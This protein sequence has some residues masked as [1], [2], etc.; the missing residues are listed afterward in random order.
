[1]PSK[2]TVLTRYLGFSIILFL[3]LTI[4]GLAVAPSYADN[5]ATPVAAPSQD[6]GQQPGNVFADVPTTYWAYDFINKLY[7]LGI[8][9]GYPDKTIK[10]EERITRAEFVSILVKALGM[11]EIISGPPVFD[12]VPRSAGYYG[13]VQSAAKAGLVAGGEGN[14]YP[15][16][17]I[18]RQEMFI[19]LVKTLKV[20]SASTSVKKPYFT[21]VYQLA[22]WV[23]AY[24]TRA[25]DEGLAVGYPDLTLKPEID[26]TRAEAYT[27]IA[28]LVL[29]MGPAVTCGVQQQLLQI[30]GQNFQP[31]EYWLQI[32]DGENNHV[33]T[34]G[35]SADSN[36]SFTTSFKLKGTEAE[37]TWRLDATKQVT[38]DQVEASCTFLVML[39]SIPEFPIGAT[40][41]IVAGICALIYY[42]MR[43]GK[44]AL[45][46]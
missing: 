29:R 4:G 44:E 30:S 46:S 11:T 38:P 21:D 14:F 39:S 5:E 25:T 8:T 6:Q 7:Q 18:T 2:K 10:P 12:D 1:M 15:D 35:V 28:R 27:A 16:L 13:F 36:G 45:T 3:V 34:I 24:I 26:A 40:G 23:Q 20:K 31:G 32:Y 37:G 22:P 42:R 43:K 19:I 17:P 9:L 41:A 33:G